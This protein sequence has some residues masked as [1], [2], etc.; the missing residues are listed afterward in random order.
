MS[1]TKE[2]NNPTSP[3]SQWF[4]KKYNPKIKNII[5]YH[6][7][8][9]AKS[10]ILA[11]VHGTSFALVG[12][13]I[14]YAFRK[15]IASKQ[16]NTSW[17]DDT[18]AGKILHRH[19]LKSLKDACTTQGLSEEE[20]F[21]VMLLG[22]FEGY[23][24]CYEPETIIQPF[25]KGNGEKFNVSP[26]YF[27]QWRPSIDDVVNISAH[28]PAIWNTIEH[29]ID[30]RSSAISNATFT[31][32]SALH[33]DCQMIIDQAI[34]DIR[35]TAKRKPF[36]LGNF[37]QQLSYLLHDSNDEYKIN[38]LVW[39]YSRQQVAF[40]YSVD[41]LFKDIEGTRAEYEEMISNHYQ[42]DKLSRLQPS[43]PKFH[44]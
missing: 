18:Y 32:S 3:L 15:F 9:M 44:T 1:V 10:T 14:T 20:A 7:N 34:I 36:T 33:A 29:L 35:T 11:P 26:E 38:K 25:F 19:N 4:Q 28:L 37:Y 41:Q 24:R 39:V 16:G 12:N 40:S 13:A 6:N 22:A 2:L 27:S 31:L 23:Y 42:H 30:I 5:E 17:L 43:T 8:V 21:K